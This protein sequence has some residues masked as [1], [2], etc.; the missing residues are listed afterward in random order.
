MVIENS[1]SA[2]AGALEGLIARAGELK[3]E[4]VA[5]VQS[6]R[7]DRQL[8]ARL[9]DAADDHGYLDEGLAILTID[10]FALQHRLPDG[11]TVVE[12]F[13]TQHRPSLTDGER[14]MVLGWRGVVEGCFE[15]RSIDG[16]AVVLLNLI[17]D[18]VYRV[19]SNMGVAPFARL[20]NGMFVIGRIVPLLAD[21]WLVTGNF[22]LLPKSAASQV[23]QSALTTLTA[24]PELLR[25]NPDLFRRA[26]EMQAEDRA[27]FIDLFG[28]DLVVLPVVEVR[29][30]LGEHYRRRQRKALDSLD[31]K[32]ATRAAAAGP[33]PDVL[34]DMPESLREAE[35]V[36]V[37]YDE[38]EGLNFYSD[39][40]RL[41]ALFADP[42]LVGD[43]TYLS[44][45]RGYLRDDSVSALP[46][47]RL[48]ERHHNGVD[49]VFRKLLGKPGFCWERD[50][51]DLLRCRKKEFI[52]RA[53]SPSISVLGARLAEL[54]RGGR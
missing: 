39:F 11:R 20:R 14:E 40:G 8:T 33:T 43:R 6:S 1:G 31:D 9:A 54:L 47:R 37:I 3:A 36:G 18:L 24:H 38:V 34:A 29:D 19:Y 28:A 22:A 23:A 7:F 41:E 10:H 12:R 44:V 45:L 50:G 25:R 30:K 48:A 13:V 2:A 46:I 21:E 52:D 15:V 35:T 27:D 53:P 26:W 51:E 16:G 42:V 5:F 32:A 49:P 17:D 4:L